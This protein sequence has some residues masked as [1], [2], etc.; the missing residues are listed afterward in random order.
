MGLFEDEAKVDPRDVQSIDN[1]AM[2]SCQAPSIEL[3]C[4]EA[5]RLEFS[6][7]QLEA[8]SALANTRS[9]PSLTKRT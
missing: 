1:R 2:P 5:S 4:S 7:Q 9:Q 3:A 6:L 8:L